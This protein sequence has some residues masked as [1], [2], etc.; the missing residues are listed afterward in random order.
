[1]PYTRTWSE[2]LVAEWLQLEGYFVEVSVPIGVTKKGGRFEADVLGIKI[3]EHILH[4]MHIEIGNLGQSA[5]KNIQTLQNKFSSQKQNAIIDYCK[6]KLGFKGR[7]SYN[8]LY[9]ATYVSK[10]TLP[11]AKKSNINLK[12][13]ED[14]IRED[15]VPAINKWKANP[16]FHPKTRGKIIML[17]DGLWLLHLIDMMTR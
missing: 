5:E 14:F 15:V 1:M 4:V 12:R 3:K 13:I 8:N 2:E 17:P 9:V 10:K 11:I 6:K 16:P 7:V